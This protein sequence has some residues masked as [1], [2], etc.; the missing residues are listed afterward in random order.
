[1]AAANQRQ[2]D[3]VGG[4]TETYALVSAG[5]A[6]AAKH[7]KAW[8]SRIGRDDVFRRSLG[9]ARVELDLVAGTGRDVLDVQGRHDSAA[10]FAVG[11][12]G[13][14]R[15]RVLS[16]AG[17]ADRTRRRTCCIEDVVGAGDFMRRGRNL[18]QAPGL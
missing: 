5:P 11:M 15:Q 10:P 18:E 16:R 7:R 4:R 3:S 1:V 9:V 12:S 13:D 14:F 6:G 2:I 17:N 8:G